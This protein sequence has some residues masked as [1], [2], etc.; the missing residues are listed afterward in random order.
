MNR[1]TFVGGE[2]V[3]K[4][5]Y[6]VRMGEYGIHVDWA[7]GGVGLIPFSEWEKNS[8]FLDRL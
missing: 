5:C 4:V 7:D 2:Y 8:R 3:G 6:W 1:Y